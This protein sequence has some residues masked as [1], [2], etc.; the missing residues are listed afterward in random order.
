MGQWEFELLDTV[1]DALGSLSVAK[2]RKVTWYLDDAA[3]ASFTIDGLH[4]QAELISETAT[5][6]R[7]YDPDH[8][9]RFRG[10]MGS[11]ND[12]VSAAGHIS[13]LTAVDYRG[14]L[15]R[16][17]IWPT[18]TQS[19]LTTEQTAIGWQLINE[20]QA[21][22]GGALGITDGSS[23]TGI[24]R[25][26]VYASGAAISKTITDLGNLAS[27]FDWEI[28]PNL[29][30]NTFYPQRGIDPGITIAYGAEIASFRQTID[31]GT[32]AT[33]IRYS[34]DQSLVEQVVTTTTFG[35]AGRWE[36][37][38]GDPSILN[39]SILNNRAQWELLKDQVLT[40]SYELTLRPG[41]WTPDLLWLGD[42]VTLV[43]K[44][45]KINVNKPF[46]I[47]RV[48]VTQ[49]DDGGQVVVLGCGNALTTQEKQLRQLIAD[50]I[51]LQKR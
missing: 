16:R 40:P 9:V 36:I 13:N 37:Q 23:A 50:V 24:T 25:S 10:R 15:A 20:S 48:D 5:D 8:T 18:S 38:I 45:G 19:W 17:T 22:P 33:A 46:R 43:L 4:P 42:T 11:S 44:S 7:V 30:F 14:F 31:T 47:V 29:S 49:G 21:L 39:Q 41:W 6:L 35:A 51:Q 34:G 2:S 27:G 12:D 26:P 1:G 28:D 3:K 32:F